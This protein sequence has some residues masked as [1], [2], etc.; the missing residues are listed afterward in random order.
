[1]RLYSVRL[2]IKALFP[3]FRDNPVQI[4]L[5][6]LVKLHGGS[7]AVKRVN[8]DALGVDATDASQPP[9]P[10]GINGIVERPTLLL[11]A[12]EHRLNDEIA[13]ERA[14][15][16]GNLFNFHWHNGR[17]YRVQHLLRA[18]I[19][20]QHRILNALQGGDNF[21]TVKLRGI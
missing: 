9:R 12:E 4:D 7:L 11:T 15:L 1:M 6:E 20:L 5:V 19:Q 18:G 14:E 10:L 2:R 13:V 16:F 17:V 21:R 3:H 8:D